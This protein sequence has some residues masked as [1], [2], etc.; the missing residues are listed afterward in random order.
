MTFHYDRPNSE[1]PQ[2]MLLVTPS[3]FTGSWK[4]DDVVNSLHD[5]LEM[6]QFRAIEP[7]Q[8]DETNY[9]KFLPTTVATV[10][11]YPVTMALNYV[12]KAFTD[13]N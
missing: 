3:E 4:W 7:D 6:M 5:T 2:S 9:A 12:A 8:V 11:T 10:T 13:N 1:P